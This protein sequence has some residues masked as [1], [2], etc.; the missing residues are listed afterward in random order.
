MVVLSINL[1]EFVT[2]GFAITVPAAI[3]TWSG[4]CQYR[5]RH[6]LYS[7]RNLELSSFRV[8]AVLY[9]KS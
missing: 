7:L 9:S 1:A 2:L 6:L 8:P 4:M 3:V 5:F